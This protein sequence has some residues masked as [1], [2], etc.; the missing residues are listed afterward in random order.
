MQGPV[1][2][3]KLLRKHIVE[4]AKQFLGMPYLWGGRSGCGKRQEG[5]GG[6]ERK[7]ELEVGRGTGEAH[8]THDFRTVARGVDCSGLTNLAYRVN[9]IGIPR[10]ARDQWRV[11]APVAFDALEPADLIFISAP[12]TY[13]Q[14]VH[15]MMYLG[16][17]E[18]IEAVETGS[19]VSARN[20]KNKY[21]LTLRETA[22]QGYTVNKRRIYFGSILTD[23]GEQ[24][25]L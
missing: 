25:A 18:F 15:V 9:M 22:E 2:D 24:W 5:A 12:E 6:G 7:P 13:D 10:D 8:K 16:D 21:G 4:T 11:F 19:Y 14:I 1:P 17:E 23:S 20:L 3:R